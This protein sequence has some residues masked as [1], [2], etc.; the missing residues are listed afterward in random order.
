MKLKSL[1]LKYTYTLCV[2]VT[3]FVIYKMSDNSA[4]EEAMRVD[5]YSMGPLFYI[6]LIVAGMM[7]NGL[8]VLFTQF[9][10]PLQKK[11]KVWMNSIAIT[12]GAILIGVLL[13]FLVYAISMST[14]HWSFG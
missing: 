9:A 10:A 4:F 1:P 13:F 8:I 7:C 6:L 14:G 12:V 11:F 2:T 3:P 5:D